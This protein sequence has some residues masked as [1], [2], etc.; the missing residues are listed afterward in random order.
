[1]AKLK[2]FD[3]YAHYMRAVQAPDMDTEFIRDAYKE[4]RGGRPYDIREDF[5]G[6]FANCCQWVKEHKG[7]RAIGIDGAK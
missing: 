6:T 7:N 3:R 4:L 1:M 5:C 2:L